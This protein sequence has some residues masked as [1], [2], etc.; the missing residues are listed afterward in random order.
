MSLFLPR[1][2]DFLRTL[3]VLLLVLG[4]LLSCMEAPL[5]VF[6]VF[7]FDCNGNILGLVFFLSVMLVIVF[8]FD[9]LPESIYFP[10]EVYVGILSAAIDFD[11]DLDFDLTTFPFRDAEVDL[12]LDGAPPER[13]EYFDR[14]SALIF[15]A[16]LLACWKVYCS[17]ERLTGVLLGFLFLILDIFKVCELALC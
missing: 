12:T 17:C 4:M 8:S 15:Y 6:L 3:D 5:D 9:L 11:L 14:L 2:A 16:T 1:D 10:K 13:W 7:F